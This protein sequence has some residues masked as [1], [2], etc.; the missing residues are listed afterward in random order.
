MVSEDGRRNGS[1][2]EGN[3]LWF[4]VPHFGV[5]VAGMLW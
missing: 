3:S 2:R 1:M 5:S 4:S